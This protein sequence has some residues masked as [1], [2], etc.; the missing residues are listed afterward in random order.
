MENINKD[1]EQNMKT[2]SS[3][4]STSK[5]KIRGKKLLRMLIFIVILGIAAFLAIILVR[6]CLKKEDNPRMETI[7]QSISEI[8]KIS[9]F[10]TA[11]YFGEVMIQDVEK[12]FFQNKKIIIIASGKVRAG[13]D[14]SKMESQIINDTTIKLIL[15]PVRVLDIITN[16]SNFRTFSERGSWSHDRVTLTKNAAR[17][18]I[19]NLALA[20]K[21]L[22]TA[23]ENGK[24]QLS[25]MFLML[26]FKQVDISF[27][28]SKSEDPNSLV[29][30]SLSIKASKVVK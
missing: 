7:D 25:Q 3:S 12:K 14:L 10:C 6:G 11:N 13:F 1:T 28:P 27:L 20:D 23:E 22:F 9:E 26:G 17:K 2:F 30:D 15:P 29:G 8:K 24:K 4:E 18:E 19:L 16:P 21:I 5:P